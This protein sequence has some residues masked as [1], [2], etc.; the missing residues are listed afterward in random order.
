MVRALKTIKKMHN[1]YGE[2]QNLYQPTIETGY[3]LI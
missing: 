2:L 3:V 1:V